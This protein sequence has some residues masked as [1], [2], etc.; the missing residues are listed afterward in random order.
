MTEI[1]QTEAKEFA[2]GHQYLLVHELAPE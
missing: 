2:S 1:I